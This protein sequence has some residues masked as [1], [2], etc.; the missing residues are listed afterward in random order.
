MVLMKWDTVTWIWL[1]NTQLSNH[2]H[3]NCARR[4]VFQVKRYGL[5]NKHLIY[6]RTNQK[7]HGS[8]KLSPRRKVSKTQMSVFSM[9][10]DYFAHS[11]E[12][13][14]FFRYFQVPRR[15]I[16]SCFQLF[17]LIQ[18][19]MLPYRRVEPVPAQFRLW[20]NSL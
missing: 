1:W 11:R 18:I 4:T 16:L 7:K 13:N 3:T 19:S 10:H 15:A 9:F 12:H 8:H 5:D 20:Q 17:V 6:R 14:F 2:L